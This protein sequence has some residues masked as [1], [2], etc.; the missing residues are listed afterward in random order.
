MPLLSTCPQH[1]VGAC[2]AL[3]T[4]CGGGSTLPED[5]PG[6]PASCCEL[7][8][9]PSSTRQRCSVRAPEEPGFCIPDANRP[10]PSRFRSLPQSAGRASSSAVSWTC[11]EISASSAAFS[12]APGLPQLAAVQKRACSEGSVHAELLVWKRDGVWCAGLW[13]SF[14]TRNWDADWDYLGSPF[15]ERIPSSGASQHKL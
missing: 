14:Q 1:L 4:S 8:S 2:N 5:R 7:K 12:E 3:E 11:R 10:P 9:S 6:G 13:R 15:S